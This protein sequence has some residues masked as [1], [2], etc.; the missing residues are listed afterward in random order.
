MILPAR[1]G[2]S[3]RQTVPAPRERA[4]AQCRSAIR[5]HDL[6]AR[7]D[8]AKARALTRSL[9]SK[10]ERADVQPLDAWP[11]GSASD[12]AWDAQLTSGK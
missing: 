8:H 2:P 3:G 5:G 9:R 4:K 11:G 6:G 1:C 10:T 7:S 12:P